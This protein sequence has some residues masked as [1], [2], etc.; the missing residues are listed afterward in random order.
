VGNAC[1]K[2]PQQ[3]NLTISKQLFL[4]IFQILPVTFSV[5]Q[6]RHSGQVKNSSM[7]V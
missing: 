7:K 4:T 5:Q 6:K 2:L 3:I 1:Q